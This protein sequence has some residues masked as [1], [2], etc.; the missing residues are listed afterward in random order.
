M[1]P[2]SKRAEGA[3]N[4]FPDIITNEQYRE[5]IFDQLIS[6]APAIQ[7]AIGQDCE[8]VIHDFSDLEHSII[9]IAG[10]VTNR[11]VGGS[12]TDLGLEKVRSGETDDLYNYTT[13]LK[14]GRTL[15][16]TSAFLRDE[17]GNV[18]GALCINV[19]ITPFLAFEHVMRNILQRNETD[20]ITETFSDDIR[21]VLGTLIQDAT[22]EIGKPL[23]LMTRDEKI[24][25]I[26]ILDNKGTFQVKKAVPIVADRLG[27]SRYTVYNYLNEARDRHDGSNLPAESN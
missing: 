7:N 5:A 11:K 3:M 17:D 6:L 2:A 20:G 22:Y 1:L 24:E 13:H 23:A 12:L 9:A 21:E 15:K 26:A 14:D 18:F 10:N 27:V 4:T 25:L 16:S 8:V 19:D